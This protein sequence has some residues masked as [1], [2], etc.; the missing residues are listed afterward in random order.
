[1]GLQHPDAPVQIRS[2]PLSEE[3][4]KVLYIQGFSSFSVQNPERAIFCRERCGSEL[5]EDWRKI[6]RNKRRKG[7]YFLVAKLYSSGYNE[8]GRG[9]GGILYFNILNRKDV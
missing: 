6:S 2:A 5:L 1:M 4:L 9:Q 8:I 3:E 7:C